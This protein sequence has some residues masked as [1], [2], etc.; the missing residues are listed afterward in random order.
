MMTLGMVSWKK[1]PPKYRVNATEV[2]H[3][4]YSQ[5]QTPTETPSGA[6]GHHAYLTTP[7]LSDS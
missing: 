4:Y 7:S 2:T 5:I 3:T 1:A 6:N